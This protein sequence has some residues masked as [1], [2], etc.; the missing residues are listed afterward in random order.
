MRQMNIANKLTVFRM[1]LIPIFLVFM[2]LPN[3]WGMIEL[4]RAII[5][6]EQFIAGIIFIVASFTDYLD[7]QLARKYNLITSFGEFFD[8]MADKLL[9]IAAFIVLVE[10]QLIPAWIIIIII[11][12]ELLVTGLRVLL[13]RSNGRVLAAALPGKI[14]TMTQMFSIIFFLF[15]DIGFAQ[16]NIPIAQILLYICLVFTIYSGADYFYKGRFVFNNQD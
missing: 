13:A 1:F 2:Y 7:G 3:N 6:T 9:V 14:K 4:G 11:S 10:R 12:R 5:P 16:W 8:P 15:N